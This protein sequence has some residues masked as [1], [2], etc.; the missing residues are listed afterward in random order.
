MEQKEFVATA[1]Y[2]G[3]CCNGKKVGQTASG[4]KPCENHTCEAGEQ[5][6]FGT[7]IGWNRDFH[8]RRQW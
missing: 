3:M 8:Y 2:G 7:R 6:K 1:Y 4:E 5:Y